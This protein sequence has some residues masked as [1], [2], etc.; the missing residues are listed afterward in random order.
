M[1]GVGA[2]SLQPVSDQ[3]PKA[4][5]IFLFCGQ[6]A[7][8]GGLCGKFLLTAVPESG[9]RQETAVGQPGEKFFFYGQGFTD[10]CQYGFFV[11]ICVGDGDKQVLADQVVYFT[12]DRDAFQAE[13]GGYGAKALGYIN[14]KILHGRCLRCLSADTQAGTAGTPGS[15]LT[16]IAKHLMIHKKPP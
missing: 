8:Y 13:T 9:F 10:P 1:F 7:G 5:D 11:E 15:L 4:A 6:N 2:E 14:Q 12:A 16:L 3:F